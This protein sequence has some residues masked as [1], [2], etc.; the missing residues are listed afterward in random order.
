MQLSQRRADAVANYLAEQG[1]DRAR[2]TAHG[3]GPD[4]PSGDNTTPA[5]QAQN[6]RIEFYVS[7][8]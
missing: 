8:A 5:G 4:R 3:Y 6:R 7:G 1:V 2:L